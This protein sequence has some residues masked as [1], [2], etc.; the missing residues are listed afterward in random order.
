M[1]KTVL[2]T[3]VGLA[4]CLALTQVNAAFLIIHNKTNCPIVVKTLGGHDVQS[5]SAGTFVVTPN[6]TKNVQLTLG[7]GATL[8]AYSYENFT[9]TAN[10]ASGFNSWL[11]TVKATNRDGFYNWGIKLRTGVHTELFNLNGFASNGN[12]VYTVT[13]APS[14]MSLGGNPKATERYGAFCTN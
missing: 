3:A 14:K 6:G 8:G 4:S 10:G 9:I 11:G 2:I 5:L 12:N 7:A 1:K 13:V